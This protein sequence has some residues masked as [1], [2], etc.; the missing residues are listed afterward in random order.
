MS[1]KNYE[2]AVKLNPQKKTAI[3]KLEELQRLEVSG[4]ERRL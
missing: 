2:T 4:E 1:I 3:K